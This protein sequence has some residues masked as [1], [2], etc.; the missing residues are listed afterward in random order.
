M[1]KPSLLIEFTEK[2][3]KFWGKSVLESHECDN[4]GLSGYEIYD[5]NK[6]SSEDGII[7]YQ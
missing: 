3:I 7:R 5:I 4:F 2:Y 6:G 1:N